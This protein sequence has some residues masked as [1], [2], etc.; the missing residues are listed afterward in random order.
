MEE[1]HVIEKKILKALLDKDNVKPEEIAKLTSLSKDAVY[2]GIRW[3][4]SKNLVKIDRKIYE[5]VT[6]T[7]KGK[8]VLNKG[9]PERVIINL[10]AKAPYTFEDL[11]KESGLNKDEFSGA[12]GY[13]KKVGIIEIKDGKIQLTELGKEYI[14]SK[15]PLEKFFDEIKE[16]K[17]L[18]TDF[19]EEEG[20]KIAKE[21]GLIKITIKAEE[22]VSL[23]KSGKDIAKKV[24]IKEEIGKLTPEII[25]KG[26]WKGKSFRAYDLKA[27]VPEIEMGKKHPYIRFIEELKEKL[28]SYGFEEMEGP[29]IEMMFWNCDCLF[30]PQDHPAREI[31]D[32]F[33]IKTIKK[34]DIPTEEL[35]KVKREHEEYWKYKFDE[36]FSRRLILR[37]HV[38]AISARKLRNVKIPG[39]YF[40]I[41]KVFR[42]DE[43]DW[44]HFIEFYQLEGIIVDEKVSFCNLLYIME[45]IFK[46]LTGLKEIKFVPGYFPFTEPS[47][48]IFGKVDGK[49][50][51][52]GGAG[53][54]RPQVVRPVFGRFIP[55]IAWGL[56]LDRMYLARY[57]LKDIREIHTYK[58]RYLRDVPL[59]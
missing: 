58:L 59:K 48:E 23:T 52:L 3:L 24:E 30:M 21:R 57:G 55:V 6:L 32:I 41:A 17:K 20:L 42:P 43:I 18:L 54:F 16:G 44:K 2:R 49:W 37:S 38:T 15:L 7:D 50:I 29:I 56:G 11:K 34:G 12:I 5:I 51:E 14:K 53:L 8:K 4:H 1:L 46:N 36:D 45:E 9:T 40:A 22:F 25:K 47:L 26:L 13:L 31:H 28:I 35:N 10:L 19:S 33:Y 27:E 39:K